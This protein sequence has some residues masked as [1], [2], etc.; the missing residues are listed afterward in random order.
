[1]T[2]HSTSGG[3]HPCR[4][5]QFLPGYLYGTRYPS[6]M[7]TFEIALLTPERL[8]WLQES[9]RRKCSS[10]API[11]F[12]VDDE[13][14]GKRRGVEWLLSAFQ[15]LQ[16]AVGLPVYEAGYVLSMSTTQARCVVPVIRSA[17]RAVKTL[18]Q[19][20]VDCLEARGGG[21]DEQSAARLNQAIVA[22]Q[23]LSPS[24]SN[25]PR[26][27]RAAYELGMP[28]ME[29]PG[30]VYQYGIGARA[31]WL[32][33]SFTDV[34]PT[35]STKLSRNK[36]YAAAL[37]KLAG[38]PV[39][40]HRQVI[41]ADSAVN[42]A[43][44][45]GYPVVV[46][47]ANLDGG[48]G[49]A[50]GLESDNE[51]RAAYSAAEKYSREI[52]VEKHVAGK[53]YRLTV[54][55]GALIWAIERMP[56]GVTGDGK[57][58][59]AELVA[60]I[61]ADPRR[62]SD[63]HAPLKRLVLDDEA[64]SLLV[65]QHS[66]ETAVPAEGEFVRLRRIAN[67]A[68]GGTP[69][70]V[71]DKVHPDNAQLVIRAA[72][73]LRLDLAGVDL[74]IP[75]ISVSWRVS[76]AAICEV[77]GQPNLGQ[78]TAAH[79]YAP[80]LQNLVPGSGRVPTVLVMGAARPQAW[81]DALAAQWEADGERVGIV[82]PAGVTV[83]DT[84]IHP[85][86]VSPYDGGMMLV[87]NRRVSAII[88]AVND[89]SGLQKGLAFD[90]C[91][92]IVLAGT[93]FHFDDIADSEVPWLR[94]SELLRSVLPACDGVIL[95]PDDSNLTLQGH[96]GRTG[97]AWHTLAGSIDQFAFEALR[98]IR[99]AVAERERKLTQIPLQR[100]PMSADSQAFSAG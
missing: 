63:R 54:F 16:A 1:M 78:T 39:P 95:N 53:D 11:A 22:L 81:L 24:G 55:N 41:D 3:E 62:R 30:D 65:R 2:G 89:G 57:S 94:M 60:R 51:V 64:L 80:I 21:T 93:N 17:Q 87:M 97:A 12:D 29:L 31:R 70:A 72:E 38:L 43:R 75:D 8:A 76:G 68:A 32:D 96:A 9:L 98:L 56:G 61:N 84:L 36:L 27:I 37:L 45:L 28:V 58:T 73:A 71:F 77:N 44:R 74:L 85:A 20:M 34:T 35:V 18:I 91:D 67:V 10:I 66:S 99:A 26:F 14:A 47:P 50:A 48:I 5:L 52:L 15:A 40:A 42:V 4:M 25:V 100:R 19:I 79:L 49:V 59:V 7:V 92:A 82:G 69:V 90:R 46:K 83:G 88:V 23:S 86:P 33:S 6:L 13:A